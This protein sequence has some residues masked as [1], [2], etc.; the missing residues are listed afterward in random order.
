MPSILWMPSGWQNRSNT[1]ELIGHILGFIA[2]AFYFLS[3]QVH[4]K[5]KLIIVQS[6]ATDLICIQ[7]ILIGA[8]SGFALNIVCL[9]RN[10]FFYHREK[11]FFS[12]RSIPYAFALVM[13]AVSAFSWDGLHSL[14]IV[15]GL[16]INTVC[17]GVCNTQNLRKSILLTSSMIIV[18]NI[19]A[20]SYS[21]ITSESISILSALIG[22][23][24]YCRESRK[25]LPQ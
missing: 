11:K 24:R 18:Y 3:Y 14:L 10:F 15:G 19:F 13:A 7:Y 8:Y 22:I 12:A 20:H 9:I 23:I 2:I 16:M 17:L 4:D 1:L 25:P 21:G 6:V 5:K